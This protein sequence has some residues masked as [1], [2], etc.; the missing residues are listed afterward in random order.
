MHN[1]QLLRRQLEKAGIPYD[2]IDFTFRKCDTNIRVSRQLVALL[3]ELK[4]GKDETYDMVI[5]CL[6][7]NSER[8]HDLKKAKLLKYAPL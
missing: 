6:I 2:S 5:A 3:K 8:Y 7:A 1:E 4:A